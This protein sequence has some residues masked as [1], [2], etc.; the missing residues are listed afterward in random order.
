MR[1]TLHSRLKLNYK[2]LLEEKSKIYPRTGKS[3]IESLQ[4]TMY[5]RLTMKEVTDL[6]FFLKIH[7]RTDLEWVTGS[8][9][10]NLEQG[11]A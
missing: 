2:I 5:T 10:F 11:V 9:L 1:T 6:T 8:D 4:K 7:P 3:I